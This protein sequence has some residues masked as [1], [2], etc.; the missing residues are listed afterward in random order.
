MEAAEDMFETGETRWPIERNLMTT[1][2]TAVVCEGL[3]TLVGPVMTPH[4]EEVRYMPR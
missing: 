3:Y 4:L 2:L 1:G